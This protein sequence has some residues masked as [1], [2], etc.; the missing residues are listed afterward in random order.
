MCTWQSIT[1]FLDV[2]FFVFF[3]LTVVAIFV[4]GWGSLAA[5][6]TIEKRAGGTDWRKRL[7][8]RWSRDDDTPSNQ[9]LRGTSY[10]WLVPVRRLTTIAVIAAIAYGSLSPTL[11]L[12]F[13]KCAEPI[14][15]LQPDLS[16]ENL[17]SA[18][19]VP[20]EASVLRCTPIPI[21]PHGQ[22]RSASPPGTLT[23]HRAAG[24]LCL[25]PPAVRARA[26]GR[27]R[28]DRTAR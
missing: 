6:A 2:Y 14:G 3:G 13:I 18:R 15:F 11:C 10:A 8:K 1:Y 4:T 21:R 5:V 7:R 28:R 23:T 24:R 20:R 19:R 22:A 17:P 26:R 16:C 25:P 9:E 27:T 12:H